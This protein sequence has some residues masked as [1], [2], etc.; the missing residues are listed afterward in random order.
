MEK[1]SELQG[2]WTMMIAKYMY[3]EESLDKKLQV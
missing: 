2:S 3:A 1:L